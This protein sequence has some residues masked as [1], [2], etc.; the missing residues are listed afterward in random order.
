MWGR[1][2]AF[3]RSIRCLL[4]AHK[5]DN[6]PFGV[7]F[8]ISP[9]VTSSDGNFEIQPL[10]GVFSN[11]FNFLWEG[12]CS[13]LCD[14]SLSAACSLHTQ[15]GQRALRGNI[16]NFPF[17]HIKWRKFWSKTPSR[18]FSNHF[19]FL[20][21][22]NVRIYAMSPSFCCLLF[23]HKQDNGPFG[24]ASEIPPSATPSDGNFGVKP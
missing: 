16:W 19:N 15:A 23:A 22:G 7:T 12:D 13:H 2:F 9:S 5:Q 14:V 20:C 10:V 24:V 11:H 4:F 8:E 17:I 6:G 21:E 3:M 18:G 1:M